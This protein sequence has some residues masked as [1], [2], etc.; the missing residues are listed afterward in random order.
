MYGV[1]YVIECQIC[2]RQLGTLVGKHLKSHGL[3][4]Q[5]YQEK[6]PGHPV[7]AMKPWSEELRAR[8]IQLRTGRTHS[9]ETKKKIG[10]KHKG[11]K[12]GEEEIAKWRDSYQ[13]FLQENGGSPQRGMKRS[14]EFRARMKQVAENRSPELVR[15]KVDQMLAARRGSKATAE[16]R[17]IYSNA[18][19]K[20]ITDN[21]D[22]MPQKMFNTKPERQ[23]AQILDSYNLPYQRNFRLGNRLFDFKV[24]DDVL[25]E[26]DGP[27]HR[28]LGFYIEPGASDDAKVEKL[29][30]FIERDRLKDRLARQHGYF[31][32][33]LPVG[34]N[35]PSNWVEILRYYGC[36]LFDQ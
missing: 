36:N 22:K 3:S 6:F 12:R 26:I 19:L 5:E 23:F 28:S 29:L 31:I 27:Y 2:Q 10:A 4:S 17:E 9:E 21:P 35:V 20:Y 18:R 7:S 30:K 25:I 11:K 32:Y 13:Q 1:C 16:Q 8:H 24:N 34:Q 15:Q 14:S 33:R